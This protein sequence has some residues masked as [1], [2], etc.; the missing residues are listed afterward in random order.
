MSKNKYI[1]EEEANA[2]EPVVENASPETEQPEKKNKLFSG[3]TFVQIMNGEFLTRDTFLRNLPFTFF[4]GFLLV[5]VIAW[6]YYGET[7]TKHEVQLEK[8]LGELNSEFY[9]LTTDY[10]TQ[11]GRRQI[12]LR[13]EPTGVKESTSSPKKIRVRKYVFE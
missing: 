13:L 10:N 11:R 2:E 9:T 6:G 4:V 5:F 1:T 12:A 8:E 7:V 3:R